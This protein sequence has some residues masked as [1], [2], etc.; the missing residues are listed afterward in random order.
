[1]ILVSVNRRL[2]TFAVTGT[3]ADLGRRWFDEIQDVV[4][5]LAEDGAAE[6]REGIR[7][8]VIA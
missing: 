4:L 6:P 5:S 2:G 8:E 3:V 7:T 1:M